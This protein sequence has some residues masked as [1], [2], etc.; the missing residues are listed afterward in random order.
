MVWRCQYPQHIRKIEEIPFPTLTYRGPK[1]V[2]VAD[3]SIYIHIHT[4]TNPYFKLKD[5]TITQFYY[6]KN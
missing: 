1:Q 6:L 5:D 4:Y 2:W 3:S